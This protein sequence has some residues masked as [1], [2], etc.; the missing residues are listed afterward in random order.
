M[1]K[2]KNKMKRTKKSQIGI[3]VP[4]YNV[5]KYLKRC[6]DS[7]INQSMTNIQIILIDDGSTDSSPKICDDYNEKDI[8]IRVLH[9]ENGGLSSARNAGLDICNAEYV[10]FVDSDDY[11]ERDACKILYSCLKGNKKIDLVASSYIEEKENNKVIIRHTNLGKEIL[12]S[13]QFIVKSISKN[14]YYTMAVLYLYKYSFLK[15]N[16]LRFKEGIFFEDHEFTPRVFLK[17]RFIIYCDFPFYHYMIR[18]NSIMTS[19]NTQ[20]KIEDSLIV[21]KEL[22]E[23]YNNVKDTELRKSLNGILIRYYLRTCRVRK[24][25]GWKIDNFNFEF[26][27]KYSLNLKEKMKVIVF[28]YFP[29]LY[30]K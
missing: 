23:I 16:N 21:Y 18:E 25:H 13:K 5:E 11:L 22:F 15:E 14:E 20:K 7:L 2:D 29:S 24:I 28:N 19:V 12:S 26:A 8:R 27:L 6:I 3:I 30:T 17:A 9:K 1:R 4:V 10:M